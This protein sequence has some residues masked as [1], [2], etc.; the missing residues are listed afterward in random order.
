MSMKRERITLTVRFFFFTF[1]RKIASLFGKSVDLGIAE[2]FDIEVGL[3]NDF[4]YVS[5][6]STRH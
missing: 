4:Y 6:S 3:V 2:Y 5:E 1:E